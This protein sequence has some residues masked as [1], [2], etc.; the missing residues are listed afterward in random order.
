MDHGFIDIGT[1]R[2]PGIMMENNI[3]EEPSGGNRPLMDPE[4]VEL[5]WGIVPEER[6]NKDN[7]RTT[8]MQSEDAEY[9]RMKGPEAE[10]VVDSDMSEVHVKI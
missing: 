5:V 2:A 4:K 3:V 9:N 7:W 1:D 8:V 10:V 6:K